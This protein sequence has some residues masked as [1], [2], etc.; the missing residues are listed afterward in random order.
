MTPERTKII[1][2]FELLW[3]AFTLLVA[4]VVLFPIFIWSPAFPF[5]WDNLL[6]IITFI[7]L[8]RYIFLLPHTFLAYRQTPKLVLLF[9]CIPFVFLLIQQLNSFQTFLDENGPEA[10]VGALSY[11]QTLA[12][13]GYARSEMLLFAVG[14]I[15][16]AVLFPFR[17][18]VSVWRVRNLGKE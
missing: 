9:L 11:E 12:M 16:S 13:S 8:G 6:F 10:L 14:S 1:W 2:R 7:T 5:Y 4:G 17:M 18:M 3:W 15:V